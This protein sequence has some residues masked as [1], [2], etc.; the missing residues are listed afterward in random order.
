MSAMPGP[1]PLRAGSHRV[2]GPSA[3]AATC[4]ASG[5]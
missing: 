3:L 5:R 4:A 2:H 1:A